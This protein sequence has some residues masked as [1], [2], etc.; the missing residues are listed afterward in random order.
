MDEGLHVAPWDR[1]A[2]RARHLDD[3]YNR[4]PA[5][6]S[7]LLSICSA[8]GRRTRRAL[9]GSASAT[10]RRP[11]GCALNEAVMRRVSPDPHEVRLGRT[12]AERGE[13]CLTDFTRFHDEEA[14][15]GLD[16]RMALALTSESPTM[17]LRLRFGD[18]WELEEHARRLTR[19]GVGVAIEPKPFDLIV[20]L[21]RQR[22]RVV[23][24]QELHEHLWPRTFVGDSALAQCIARARHALGDDQ[25]PHRLIETVHGRGF[26]F[27]GEVTIDTTENWGGP[28][29]LRQTDSP[30]GPLCLGGKLPFVGRKTELSR[31]QEAWAKASSGAPQTVLVS[32]EPGIGKSRLA[33]EVMGF[34]TAQHGAALVG[35]CD[36]D[37]DLPYQPFA[38][39]IRQYADR[40]PI[41]RLRR[42][43]GDAPALLRLLPDLGEWIGSHSP[44]ATADAETERYRLF[45]AVTDWLIAAA[46]HAPLVLVLED[47]HRA[48]PHTALLLRHLVSSLS[49]S[50]VRVPLLLVVTY[51]DTDLSAADPF[52]AILADLRALPN[53]QSLSL[54][55]LEAEDIAVLWT[56]ATGREIR[57][58][59]AVL[60]RD[61]RTRT[62]G[63]PLFAGEII[64]DL[65]QRNVLT[66]DGIDA[67]GSYDLVLEIPSGVHAL[68]RQRVLRL[69]TAAREALPV[70][71]LIGYHFDTVVLARLCAARDG[72][73]FAGLAEATAARLIEEVSPGTY[74]FAHAVVRQ[75]IAAELG[76]TRA[77]HLHRRIAEVIEATH[78]G[79]LELHLGA[80]AFHYIRAVEVGGAAKAVEY[81]TRAGDWAAAALAHD[82]AVVYY[83]QAL[84]VLGDDVEDRR[85]HLELLL[86]LGAAERDAGD[87]A[88]RETL[89]AAGA[90]ARALGETG[91]LVHAA[92]ANTRGFL[93]SLGRVDTER[94]DLLQAALEAVGPHDSA[95][96]A[97]LLANLA[98]ELVFAVPPAETARLADDALAVARRVDDPATL[99]H[100][101][102]RRYLTA[103]SPESLPQRV[104]MARELGAVVERLD[105]PLQT[106]WVLVQRMTLALEVGDLAELDDCQGAFEAVNQELGSPALRWALVRWQALRAL[107]AGHLDEAEQ[108]CADAFE[109]G[110]ATGQP[111]AAYLYQFQ[112]WGIREA[113]G[114]VAE[115]EP[116]VT[117]IM[118]TDAEIPAV[119]ALL[120]DFYCAIGRKSAARKLLA[121]DTETR[122]EEIPRDAAWLTAMVHFARAAARLPHGEAAA[123]LYDQ[124]APFHDRVESGGGV[125]KGSIALYLGMLATMLQRHD[126]AEVHFAEAEAVHRRLAAPLL[127]A[128]T[129]TE[130]ARMLSQR[131]RNGDAVYTKHRRLQLRGAR[132]G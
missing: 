99:A 63:N 60:V 45:A 104:A 94:V 72:E 87:A 20:Y 84:D 109:L 100:V 61:V 123:A 67:P 69:S 132:R 101:L 73:L 117:S 38:E 16:T 96:R 40:C 54:E 79:N 76:E 103:W 10:A 129:R 39:A 21:V 3:E 115:V 7:S 18:D 62:R 93:S 50:T 88:F 127:L 9:P 105:D 4:R 51:R 55:G 65:V 11:I 31:L 78:A 92:L 17:S 107:M 108:L 83:R 121:R 116:L 112:L 35:R 30:F 48:G 23:S 33:A 130:H 86:K 111:D 28:G 34:V 98:S 5:T 36:D 14:G 80:L 27:A 49:A 95:E 77:V 25:H 56:Y 118:T 114:R 44:P 13:Q 19:G 64:R 2:P 29:R 46:Q 122:F 110:K 1:R 58:H 131:L 102:Q 8:A 89:L 52:A 12:L 68:V 59:A 42:D 97:R 90:Q 6:P 53:V 22:D 85:R 32:G 74:R 43:I 57:E 37:L 47:L 128:I 125:T 126:A 119:R 106:Y 113:Q 71:A 15:S 120:A 26:R 91:A 70:A 82:Q 66:L 41:E 24:K 124:L 75:T 81:A